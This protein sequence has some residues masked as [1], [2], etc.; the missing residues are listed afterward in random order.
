MAKYT[1]TMRDDQCNHTVTI[2]ADSI[3]DAINQADDTTTDWLEGGEWG[4]DGASVSATWTL[5]D[6]AGEEVYTDSVTVEIAPNEGAL[7]P[8]TECGDGVEDH[9]WTSEGTGGCDENPGVWS[10]GGTAML[11]VTRCRCCGLL[12][13]QHC[14]G[15][16]RDPGA[17]DTVE[18][19]LPD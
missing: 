14:V 3:A 10:L 2:E 11:F 19:V 8:T 13:K 5:T 15:A 17:H 18:F 1:L 6:D 4:D 16:Q 9:E 12:R 7:I